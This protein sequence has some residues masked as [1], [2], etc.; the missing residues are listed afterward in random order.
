M[1]RSR[2]AIY[3]VHA[4]L[5]LLISGCGPVDS[6]SAQL[7]VE[8]NQQSKKF[9]LALPKSNWIDSFPELEGEVNVFIV[10][11][12]GTVLEPL[13][14]GLRGY[15]FVEDVS[16][17]GK[18][19]ISSFASL[20]MK[21]PS[22]GDLYISEP[23]GSNL[24]LLTDRFPQRF[25][26]LAPSAMWLLGRDEAVFIADSGGRAD[27]FISDSDGQH[28]NS[29]IAPEEMTSVHPPLYFSGQTYESRLYWRNGIWNPPMIVLEDGIQLYDF[30]S[31]SVGKIATE[32]EP[33][34][35]FFF[36]T[37]NDTVIISND[38]GNW[39]VDQN[40]E[41]KRRLP[42]EGT[43][44]GTFW[45]PNSGYLLMKV[46]SEDAGVNE[47]DL[48]LW[49]TG[50]LS[51]QKIST[52]SGL[53]IAT[54][55]PDEQYVAILMLEEM[56]GTPLVNSLLLDVRTRTLSPLFEMLEFKLGIPDRVH[57]LMAES[58]D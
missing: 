26:F 50:T 24:I 58:A 30:A 14:S 15:N 19:L 12:D 21:R 49:R 35:E 42:I 10:E 8:S 33:F 11:Q 54:W 4:L 29:L 5:L 38:A 6:K 43:P 28:S 37:S 34:P 20:E 44:Q 32:D 18:L 25:G 40:F 56:D 36:S 45:S 52:L 2:H 47:G 46:A 23:D 51:A 17:S 48:Y 13:V 9:L 57:W 41:L 16:A 39:L 31:N 22:Y 1:I 53:P 55:S 27:I 7:D 3:L